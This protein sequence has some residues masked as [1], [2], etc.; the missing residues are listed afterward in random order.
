MNYMMNAVRNAIIE[1]NRKRRETEQR[2]ILEHYKNEVLKVNQ[3]FK[4]DYKRIVEAIISKEEVKN[5]NFEFYKDDKY[6]NGITTQNCFLYLAKKHQINIPLATQ[7]F[8]N[9]KLEKYNFESNRY[10]FWGD[11]RHQRGSTKIYEYFSQIYEKV[12]NEFGKENK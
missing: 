10:S 6:E 8:I 2:E 1:E 7:G 5:I 4:E 3:K 11:K 12:K 9:N